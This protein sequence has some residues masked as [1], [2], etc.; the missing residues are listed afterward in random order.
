MESPAP[1]QL[2]HQAW[3]CSQ[4]GRSD[5][6]SWHSCM[7]L[8]FFGLISAQSFPGPFLSKLFPAQ[9]G[10][11]PWRVEG[12]KSNLLWRLFRGSWGM[13]SLAEL[14]MDCSP[15]AVPWEGNCEPGLFHLFTNFTLGHLGQVVALFPT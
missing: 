9:P 7:V 12:C 6:L 8:P 5:K 11:I 13:Q 3:G 14:S 2:P 4:Q 10:A 1:H 15:W